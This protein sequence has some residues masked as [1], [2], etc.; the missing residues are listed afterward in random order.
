MLTVFYFI[1]EISEN[2]DPKPASTPVLEEL[3]S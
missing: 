2:Q 1:V 3:L